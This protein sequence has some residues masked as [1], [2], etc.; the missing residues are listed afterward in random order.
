MLVL[1]RSKLLAK[2]SGEVAYLLIVWASVNIGACIGAW[3]SMTQF[4][5]FSLFVGKSLQVFTLVNSLLAHQETNTKTVMIVCPLS[6]IHNWM[7]EFRI[8]LPKCSEKKNVKTFDI[9]KW[10]KISI[11]FNNDA[12][13]FLPRMF[14]Y[15]CRE[16]LL[17]SVKNYEWNLFQFNISTIGAK[18]FMNDREL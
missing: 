17:D 18:L 14:I 11:S 13:N 7:N 9:S 2:T 8:W 12:D 3:C 16:S 1:N 15:I 6:T 10:V 4:I 5:S